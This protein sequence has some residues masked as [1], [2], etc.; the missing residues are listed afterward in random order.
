MAENVG[1]QFWQILIFILIPVAAIITTV[2][3][4]FKGRR[5]KDLSYLTSSTVVLPNVED[6]VRK[7]LKILFGEKEVV[8]IYLNTFTF[9]CSGNEPIRP[10]DY[11]NPIELDFG[12]NVEV[13]SAE[14][15]TPSQRCL[16]PELRIEGTSVSIAP[17][18]MN[19]G[20]RIDMKILTDNPSEQIVMHAHIAGVDVIKDIKRYQKISEWVSFTGWLVTGM[21]TTLLIMGVLSTSSLA[22]SFP[23]ALILGFVITGSIGFC[24]IEASRFMAGPKL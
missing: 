13:L 23:F 10:I 12:P 22:R 17:I 1:N 7:K 2:V 19:H 8:Q 11:E 18:L 5:R 20:D 4:W 6:A 16:K 15:A 14:I 21:A 24:L 3:L 9:L